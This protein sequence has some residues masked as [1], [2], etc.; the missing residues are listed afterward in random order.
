MCIAA[1]THLYE[2]LKFLRE[3]TSY[4]LVLTEKKLLSEECYRD[5]STAF[6][7]RKKQIDKEIEI[8]IKYIDDES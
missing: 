6:L 7:A 2:E 1:V 3:S 4:L 8:I 5:M